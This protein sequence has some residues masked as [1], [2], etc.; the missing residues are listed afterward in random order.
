MSAV[1]STLN[2]RVVA[3]P[4][5]SRARFGSLSARTLVPHAV[6][7]RSVQSSSARARPRAA[8]AALESN[9][10]ES[11]DAVAYGEPVTFKFHDDGASADV[12]HAR[13]GRLLRVQ[14]AGGG[15]SATNPV[16]VSVA[17]G[18]NTVRAVA[19]RVSANVAQRADRS[20]HLASDV[21]PF[22]AER[23]SL[24]VV[25]YSFMSDGS[26]VEFDAAHRLVRRRGVDGKSFVNNVVESAQN[27][28][29]A[30]TAPSNATSA[31]AAPS[32][33]S[34]AAPSSDDAIDDDDS[35]REDSTPS[36]AKPRA[37][38]AAAVETIKSRASAAV[39]FAVNGRPREAPAPVAVAPSAQAWIDAWSAGAPKS[40]LDA[41]KAER[42]GG[43]ND[44]SGSDALD[45]GAMESFGAGAGARSR[46]DAV[47]VSDDEADQEAMSDVIAKAGSRGSRVPGL[48]SS[49]GTT[50]AAFFDLDG[51]V[52]RSNVV[53]QYAACRL[54][55]MPTW[56]KLFWVPLYL[57]KCVLYLVV[58]KFNRSAFN[59]LFARDFRGLPSDPDAKAAMAATVYD[60][61][62][63]RN[64]F[65]AA[66]RTIAQLKSEGFDVVLV[67]GSIDFL[68]APLARDLGAT[69]VIANALEEKHG[70]F[71][72]SLVGAPVA[73]EE[74]RTRVLAYAKKRAVDLAAS[75][76]FGDSVADVPMLEC[77]GEPF[78]VS[79]SAKLRAEANR[80][81]WD[82]LEWTVR[83]NDAEGNA[84]SAAAA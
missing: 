14:S 16:G 34:V 56:L 27:F 43:P 8:R 52:A 75:R 59:T 64:I 80:R 26:S 62:L 58:D 6:P 69:E 74:K 65:P 22:V 1:A 73:D 82:V 71:T 42:A 2:A 41:I 76:A 53:A 83:E 35:T 68:V 72:G 15:V 12:V 17:R 61:Y 51:T 7:A 29:A 63:R 9:P 79:P 31:A 38:L 50:R 37:A 36:P 10:G 25:Y 66:A 67:T 81:G 77:V 39:D 30:L 78:A 46:P 5:A 24:P 84:G 70:Q 4:R 55:T 48:E 57:L 44:G 32:L 11:F 3:R 40:K 20:E 13:T 54:A 60:A 18:A 47:F 23:E 19:A 45:L 33:A 28:G 21:V 49:R